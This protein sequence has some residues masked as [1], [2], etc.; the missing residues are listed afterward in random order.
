MPLDPLANDLGFETLMTLRNL[1][2]VADMDFTN[3]SMRAQFKLVD[4]YKAKAAIILGDKE[5]EENVLTIK[6]IE[7]Q[8]QVSIKIEEL[9]SLMEKW[10]GANKNE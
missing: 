2:Y 5:V 7:T 10:I 9:D 1:G 8:E 3:R 6:N 4:R